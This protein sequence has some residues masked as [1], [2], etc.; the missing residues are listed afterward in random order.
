MLN[1]GGKPALEAVEVIVALGQHQRRAA[2]AHGLQHVLADPA[3]PRLVLHQILVE[4]LELEAPIRVCSS[5][6]SC[7]ARM[8]LLV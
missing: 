7:H 1:P 4:G 8:A 6:V 3:I 2:V 5:A